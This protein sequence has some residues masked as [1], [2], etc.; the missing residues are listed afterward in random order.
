MRIILFAFLTT[1]ASAAMLRNPASKV[2]RSMNGDDSFDEQLRSA[3]E[4]L[5]NER[6]A[7]TTMRLLEQL[8]SMQD[9]IRNELSSQQAPT[10]EDTMQDHRHVRRDHVRASGDTIEEINMI[11]G[12]NMALYQGDMILTEQQASEVLADI[13]E[14]EGGYRSKRQAFRDNNYPNTTWPTGVNYYFYNA[15]SDAVRLFRKAAILW[16]TD[17]CIN[18]GETYA[19]EDAIVVIESAGCWSHVGRIGGKQLLSLGAGCEAVSIAAH[20]LAHAMGFYHTQSRHDRDNFITLDVYNIQQGWETQFTKQTPETNYNYNITYDYGTIMHYGATSASANGQPFMKTHDPLFLQTLG[21]PFISFYEKLMMNLHYKC[22]DNC[23]QEHWN[24]CK[25][26]G[27]PHPRNCNKCIC[28]SGYGGD[29]CD[30]RPAGC[31]KI[32]TATESYQTLNDSVG[33]WNY[34]PSMNSDEFYMCY[35]WIQGPPGSKIEVVFVNY[36]ENLSLDGCAYAG[37]EIKTLADKRHTGY[38]F[39]SSDYFG[40]TLISTHNIVPVITYSRVYVANTILEYRI[41]PGS[42]TEEETTVRPGKRSKKPKTTTMRTG[43]TTTTESAPTTECG[44]HDVC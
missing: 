14:N 5:K 33:R 30:Q 27:F 4:L 20:E 34:D 7:D 41:A 32:L 13:K 29:F 25:N 6:D 35:Y 19:A 31:G 2:K 22:L 21:S 15:S 26:G 23:K 28:P 18:F 24:K 17:T 37:V 38:R 11:S 43:K 8:H 3:N 44:E 16:G 36:T 1:L 39:C 10:L 42:Q 9:E 40:A 12:V